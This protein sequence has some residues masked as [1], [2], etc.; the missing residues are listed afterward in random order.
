MDLTLVTWLIPVPPLLA[1]G[2]IVL[3]LNRW[4]RTSSAVGIV[5]MLL[6]FLMAQVVFW[7]SVI[8]KG[9]ELAHE[10]IHSVIPWLATGPNPA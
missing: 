1:F 8:E 9:A 4:K 7:T 3:F 2:L 10:P 6:S 5:G